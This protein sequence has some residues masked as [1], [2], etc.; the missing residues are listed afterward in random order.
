[1]P[2]PLRF[3]GYGLWVYNHREFPLQTGGNVYFNGARA[4]FKED[5]ALNLSEVDPKAE[6]V[7]E[8]DGV[9]LRLKLGP[10]DAESRHQAR[11]HRAIG[12]GEDF[13]ASLRKRRRLALGH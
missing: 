4:Y 13:G 2:N 3:G 9:Y 5:G 8:G 12:K 7:E 10:R 11:E 1:M 6:I